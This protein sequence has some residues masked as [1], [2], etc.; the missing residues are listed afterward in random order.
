MNSPLERGKEIINQ[1]PET[2]V[3]ETRELKRWPP[4]Q[5]FLSLKNLR[6]M[7]VKIQVS[8]RAYAQLLNGSK[9][10]QGTLALASPTEG[11][12]HEHQRTW[13]PKPGT[14]YMRLPH[15]K[16]S[17]SND[18]VRMHIRISRDEMVDAPQAILGES[19]DASN[20]VEIVT[21]ECL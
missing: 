10:L 20:F 18:D 19:I 2:E 3:R 8:D 1:Q 17:V 13:R 11:N 9:R 4:S 5:S 12:F 7:E 15:G 21:D 16:I 6:I 14:Q